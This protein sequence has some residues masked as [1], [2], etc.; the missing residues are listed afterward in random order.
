[1]SKSSFSNSHNCH[2]NSYLLIT[3]KNLVWFLRSSQD[4]RDKNSEAAPPPAIP[5]NSATTISENA[6]VLQQ[7]IHA[8]RYLHF[9]CDTP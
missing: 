1:M 7:L 5:P 6:R 3:D 4:S 8:R 9:L 2:K